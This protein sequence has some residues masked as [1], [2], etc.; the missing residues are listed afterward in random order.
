MSTRGE[1]EVL[2]R[3]CQNLGKI[4]VDSDFDANLKEE[5]ESKVSS[6]GSM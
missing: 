2:Q 6:Y 3:H 1:L 4:S 5:V